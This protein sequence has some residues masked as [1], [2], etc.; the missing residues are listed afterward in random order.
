MKTPV[1]KLSKE[2]L[3]AEDAERIK[4]GF[5]TDEG[6]QEAYWDRSLAVIN[7]IAIHNREAKVGMKVDFL[8]YNYAFEEGKITGFNEKGLL[9]IS[10]TSGDY[11]R[12]VWSVFS[13]EL[14]GGIE[15]ET[16]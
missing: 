6:E 10:A 12:E 1:N 13:K 15:N 14:K 7:M 11:E 3:L 8:N 5:P 16:E 9:V 2:A 4:A